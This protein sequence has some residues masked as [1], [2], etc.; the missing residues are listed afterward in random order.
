MKRFKVI[1]LLSGTSSDGIDAA[2]VEI[3][4]KEGEIN[5]QPIAFETFPYLPEV[6]KEIIQVSRPKTSRVDKISQL[7]FLLGELFAD[8]ALK[9]ARKANISIEEIELIG[10]HGQTVHHLPTPSSFA[11]F[12]VASTLQ[13]G[14]PSIIAQRTG[15]TTVADFRPRDM[16][17][18]GCGAPLIPYFHYVAFRDLKLS[19][20]VLNIGGIANLTFIPAGGGLDDLIAFDTGPGNCLL[21]QLVSELTYGEQSYDRGGEWAQAGKV[22]EKLLSRLMQ[23]PFVR[24]IPP[25][26]TGPEE[27]NLKSLKLWPASKGKLSH[28][29]MLSTL[30]AFTAHAVAYNIRTFIFPK[31]RVDQLIV[32]GGGVKNKALV[33]T[34][35]VLLAPVHTHTFE[36]LGL[37]SDTA[38]AQGFALLAY[39]TFT[40][41]GGNLPGATG[42]RERVPLGKIVPGRRRTFAMEL[43]KDKGRP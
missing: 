10:S 33:A 42:A 18:Y 34:L 28:E 39:L 41:K 35:K 40:G 14:E 16:A 26:S 3:W 8:A 20:I 43:V 2:L 5:L 25:K 1:G 4:E 38:E 7:N 30:A 23:H 15:V 31:G 6:R 37:S 12:Q 19:R 9:V 29:D 11:G 22:H 17:A 27:F 36:E 21:D 13:L 24:R 32:G